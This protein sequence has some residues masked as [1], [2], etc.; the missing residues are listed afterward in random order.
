[1]P[2]GP[3]L[4]EGSPRAGGRR[5]NEAELPSG[6]SS[7]SGLKRWREQKND[8]LQDIILDYVRG[9]PYDCPPDQFEH[10]HRGRKRRPSRQSDRVYGRTRT[11][12]MPSR[13]RISQVPPRRV[14]IV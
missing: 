4:R 9:T 11:W 13:G 10:V 12:A 1:M 6:G 7:G 2:F 14:S 8:A 3:Q 5:I